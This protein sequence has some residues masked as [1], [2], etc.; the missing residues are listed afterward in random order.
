[1]RLSTPESVIAA[2][3][4]SVLLSSQA[5]AADTGIPNIEKIV[6]Q[7]IQPMM[8]QYRIP[9]MAVGLVKDGRHYVYDFG[10]MSKT[11]GKPVTNDTLFEIGSVSKTFTATLVSY[12]QITGHLSLSDNVSKYCRP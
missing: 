5:R 6:A 2:L 10:V 12:A 1:M 9:G 3:C 8:R 11:T 4:A 7:Q